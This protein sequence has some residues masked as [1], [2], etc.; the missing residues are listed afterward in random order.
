MKSS[1]KVCNG[2]LLRITHKSVETNCD[3]T[4]ALFLPVVEYE[5]TTIKSFS[6]LFYLS[7]LT[8]TDEN[9]CHKLGAFPALAKYSMGCIFPDTSPRGCN[10][11]GEADNWDFGVGAGFFID[12]T[13]EPW[14]TNWRME[15]YV[16]KELPNFLAVNFPCL[17]MDLVGVIGHSMGG[18]GSL[19]LAL[20][21]PHLFKSVSAFA[22]ICNPS[23][24]PWGIKAFTNYLGPDENS[25]LAHDAAQLIATSPFDDI[26]ID[27]GT[28]DSFYKQ[29]QL[30]PESLQA[31]AD[32]SGRKITLRM[33][34]GYGHDF[35]FYQSFIEEHIAFHKKR[36]S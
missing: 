34:E 19:T 8:C 17:N 28:S 32:M 23:K 25:W 31:A 7:G 36:L 14:S 13:R 21:Y 1:F 6:L 35:Y 2:I 11:P 16:T 4:F 22:P 27:V 29:G 20:K 5:T 10:I 3:M 15:S 18:H 26:L 9:A 24:C 33:Q 30:R 12:A